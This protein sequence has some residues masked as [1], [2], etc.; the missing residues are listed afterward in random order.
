M[1]QQPIDGNVDHCGADAEEYVG[2][3]LPELCIAGAT[4][5]RGWILRLCVA[6]LRRG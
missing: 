1:C 3:E 4:H 5:G 6:M 2:G